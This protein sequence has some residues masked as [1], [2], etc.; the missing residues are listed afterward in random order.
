MITEMLSGPVNLS[1]ENKT[2]C[3][4]N[5]ERRKIRIKDEKAPF[6]SKKRHSDKETIAGWLL[7]QDLLLLWQ[8]PEQVSS[9]WS[10]CN[11]PSLH[12]KCPAL[13]PLSDEIPLI[14][15]D[16]P[17]VSLPL[18]SLAKRCQAKLIT[19][20]SLLPSWCSIVILDLIPVHDARRVETTA[21]FPLF[22]LQ[23]TWQKA[24][25]LESQCSKNLLKIVRQNYRQYFNSQW[26]ELYLM[27][28]TGIIFIEQLSTGHYVGALHTMVFNPS[29]QSY[30]DSGA[31]EEK[32]RTLRSKPSL[33]AGH[34][35]HPCTTAWSRVFQATDTTSVSLKVL[36]Y[37]TGMII[38]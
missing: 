14:L 29:H 36:L 25:H 16:L 38:F 8:K 20:P 22:H 13:H 30:K 26:W 3:H 21:Q 6:I 33:T 5:P 37:K 9:P 10:G 27:C 1:Q 32:T 24:W 18:W 28:I 31:Q 17:P 34:I 19:S 35:L 15:Q 7:I 4:C 2:I 11:M 12:C 23:D